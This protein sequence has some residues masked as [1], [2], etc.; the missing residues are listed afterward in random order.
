MWAETVLELDEE[1]RIESDP[2][3]GV[4]VHLGDPAADAIGV[5]LRIPR[6][7]E[8]VADVDA[9]AVAAHLDHLRSSVERRV[10]VGRVRPAANDSTD[11]HRASEPRVER[12]A[13]VVLPE[14][15]GSP[16]RDVEKPVVER[17][18]DVAHQW[19]YRLEPLKQRR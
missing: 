9:L 5:E 1:P 18:V 4:G 7:V 12:I 8:R 11:L 15:S 17:Q 19:R 14:L 10:G 6:R 3:G 2:T 13:D 16:A